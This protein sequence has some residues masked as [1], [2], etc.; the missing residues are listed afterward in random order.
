MSEEQIVAEIQII[1]AKAESPAEKPVK[2]KKPLT[3]R[4]SAAQIEDIKRNMTVPEV[5]QAQIPEK[6]G[7]K[8]SE[9]NKRPRTNHPSNHRGNVTMENVN[10]VSVP[11]NSNNG[12]APVAPQPAPVAAQPQQPGI[13][14]KVAGVPY[15]KAAAKGALFGATAAAAGSLVFFGGRWV[16]RKIQGNPV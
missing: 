15:G 3:H 13:I 7:D 4:L 14:A 9:R 6:I 16:I 10:P 1:E 11:Q 8:N 2:D 12:V 5:V